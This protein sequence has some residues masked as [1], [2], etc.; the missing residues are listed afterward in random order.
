MLD[1]YK[2]IIYSWHNNKIKYVDVRSL[3]CTIIQGSFYEGTIRLN[4]L[5][6]DAGE[7]P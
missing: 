4:Y 1:Y 6:T 3:A 5:D 7:N 2:K